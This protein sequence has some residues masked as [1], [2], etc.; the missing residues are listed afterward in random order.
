MAVTPLVSVIISAYHSDNVIR[1][2]LESLGKQTF[3]DFETIVVNSS[4]EEHTCNIV[5]E[6]FPDTRFIQNRIRL[7]PHAA[8]NMGVNHARGKLLAFIDPDCRARADWLEVLV[9]TLEGGKEMAGGGMEPHHKTWFEM[10][11]HLTKFHWLLSG[12]QP[13]TCRIIPTSNACYSKE[14]FEIIGP[15]E[16]DFYCGD[17]IQSWRARRKGYLLWFEPRAVVEHIH[18][19][20]IASFCGERFKRGYD[21]MTARERFEKWRRIIFALYTAASP[22]L[23]LKVLVQAALNASKCGRVGEYFLTLPVQILGHGS[24]A[25]GEVCALWKPLMTKKSRSDDL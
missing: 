5:E 6:R 12:L 2:C 4:D 22:L 1:G 3:T 11:A 24:W 25:L 7:L 21:F 23:L 20:N 17:A 9:K 13:G 19:G 10:G 8:H 15:F 16:P 14:A 18:G